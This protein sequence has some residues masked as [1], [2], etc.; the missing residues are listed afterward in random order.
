MQ[1][2]FL[3]SGA[4]QQFAKTPAGQANQ[5][6]GVFSG[7][8]DTI[9]SEVKTWVKAESAAEAANAEG[10]YR[11]ELNELQRVMDDTAFYNK[12]EIPEGIKYATTLGDGTIPAHEVQDQIMAL[13]AKKLREKYT[14]GLNYDMSKA[15]FAGSIAKYE[16]A[17][18]H[19]IGINA[20]DKRHTWIQAQTK[21]YVETTIQNTTRETRDDDIND[22]TDKV[23]AAI[24]DGSIELDDG[25]ELIRNAAGEVDFMIGTRAIFKGVQEMNPQAID[26]ELDEVLYGETAMDGDQQIKFMKAAQD[27]LDDIRDQQEEWKQ[28]GQVTAEINTS[29]DIIAGAGP[30]YAEIAQQQADGI[31]DGP[32]ARRLIAQRQSAER[33]V[34]EAGM[35]SDT[36]VMQSIRA[37]LF[38]L[39]NYPNPTMTMKQHAFAMQ[40]KLISY[41]GVSGVAKDG[42]AGP[43]QITDADYLRFKAEVEKIVD[44]PKKSVDWQ[45]T[46][47]SMKV[48]ITGVPEGMLFMGDDTRAVQ[49][50]KF[51]LAMQEMQKAE[52]GNPNFRPKQWWANNQRFY[53]DDNTKAA[54]DQIKGARL[55]ESIVM[56]EGDVPV[57]GSKDNVLGPKVTPGQTIDVPATT[58]GLDEQLKNKQISREDYTDAVNRLA[59][60]DEQLKAAQDALN[61]APVEEEASMFDDL[62]DSAGKTVDNV[63]K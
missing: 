8:V 60:Y 32:G 28:E 13:E 43:A 14:E 36:R 41:R 34:N 57:I 11:T 51:G 38:A 17:A 16:T 20:I 46:A 15:A 45:E 47:K 62:L 10:Q 49:A 9:K 23:G 58:K 31:L 39:A 54:L 22:I 42:V 29:V 25:E 44:A 26:D 24:L 61:P 37:E 55:Q 21:R 27:G 33:A 4:V 30:T 63:F 35:K 59:K 2:P 5:L 53:I 48:L 50:V 3:Q 56:T 40:E 12:D 6:A 7:A 52:A 18:V 1:L 19:K